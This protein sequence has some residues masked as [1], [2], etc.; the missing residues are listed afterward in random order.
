MSR[1]YSRFLSLAITATLLTS[2]GSLQVHAQPVGACCID[3]VFGGGQ[4]NAKSSSIPFECVDTTES[5]CPDDPE[6][7]WF[8]GGTSCSSGGLFNSLEECQAAIIGLPVELI[9]FDAVTN[10]ADVVLRWSTATESDNAGFAVERRLKGDDVE[11]LGFVEGFGTTDLRQ[12]YSFVAAGLAPGL[13]RFR[14]KQIDFDGTFDYAAEVEVL[15]ALPDRF[16]IQAAYPNPFNPTTTLGFAVATD[17]P[18]TVTL[19]DAAGRTIRTLFEGTASANA[20]QRLTVDAST[21]PSGTYMVR[22]VGDEISQTER[23]VLAK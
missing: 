21:L 9:S 1:R 20:M 5:S 10:G 23:I 18:V 13:H 14:L 11:E 12:D 19:I 3:L 16:F 17:Q 15:L 6:G 4:P 8:G 22:F 2:A 7:F